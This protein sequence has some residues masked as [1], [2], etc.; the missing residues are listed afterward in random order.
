MHRVNIWHL[1][2]R[3]MYYFQ[4][5]IDSPCVR[6]AGGGQAAQRVVTSFTVEP[7][8]TVTRPAA[9]TPTYSHPPQMTPRIVFSNNNPHAVASCPPEARILVLDR[10]YHFSKITTY[11]WNGGRGAPA[12]QVM[13]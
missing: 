3:E 11:H 4:V 10:P 2:S 9:P 12:G 1:T 13:L 7:D 5:L 8:S 6:Q